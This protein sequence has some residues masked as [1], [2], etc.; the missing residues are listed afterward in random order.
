VTY[1]L[2]HKWHIHCLAYLY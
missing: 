2:S 1:T